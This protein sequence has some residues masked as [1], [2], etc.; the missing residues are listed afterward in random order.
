MH[1]SI[2][3]TEKLLLFKLIAA[4]PLLENNHVWIYHQW[5][6][7]WTDYDLKITFMLLAQL[8]FILRRNW[9]II[10]KVT[11]F[12]PVF[13]VALPSLAAF[14]IGDKLFLIFLHTSRTRFRSYLVN[15]QIWIFISDCQL[16][17]CTKN[18]VASILCSHL[19]L[20]GDFACYCCSVILSSSKTLVKIHLFYL[21]EIK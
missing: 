15:L 18:L 10:F 19:Q 4:H 3:V 13:L 17:S 1:K 20:F 11:R 7:V 8:H 5:L 9:I 16:I 14:D 2:F 12:P 6:D 21:K